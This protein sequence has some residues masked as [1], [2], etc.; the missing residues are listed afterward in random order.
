[1]KLKL[2]NIGIIKEADIKIDGLTVIAGK[3]DS[4]KST[5]SKVL[6]SMITTLEQSKFQTINLENIDYKQY[7]SKFNNA[8]DEIF[9]SQISQELGL[10]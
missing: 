4:G 9:N 5:I 6:Y 8:I 3:N 7:K 2:N 1:M 10:L